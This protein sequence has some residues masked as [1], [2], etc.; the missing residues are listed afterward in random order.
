MF[1]ENQPNMMA[2]ERRIWSMDAPVPPLVGTQA[3]L[4]EIIVYTRWDAHE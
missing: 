1:S 4:S 3:K 2:I